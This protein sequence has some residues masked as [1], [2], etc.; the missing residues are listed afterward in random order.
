MYRVGCELEL[1][2]IVGVV[3]INIEI[4]RYPRYNDERCEDNEQ[5]CCYD[6][7]TLPGGGMVPGVPSPMVMV[8]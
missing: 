1:G 4:R 8:L 2:D 5:C 7:E 3:I 6:N